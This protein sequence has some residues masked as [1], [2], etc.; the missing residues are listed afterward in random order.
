MVVLK[1]IPIILLYIFILGQVQAAKPKAKADV[2]VGV[3]GKSRKFG[4]VEFEGD[5][6]NLM[7]RGG[8]GR[9]EA[10][11]LNAANL[12]RRYLRALEQSDWKTALSMCSISVMDKAQQYPTPESFFN[13]VVPVKEILNK[14]RDPR[15]GYWQRPPKYF[16]YIFNVGISKPDM[17]YPD[18]SPLK[19]RAQ[20]GEF[21]CNNSMTAILTT[22]VT[23]VLIISPTLLLENKLRSVPR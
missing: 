1:N 12:I 22:R 16:A 14:L 10:L 3:D 9:I 4:A 19:T 15:I 5:K 17:P 6:Y 21:P 7:A 20:A 2:P 11:D 8:K 18:A 13:I 23:R